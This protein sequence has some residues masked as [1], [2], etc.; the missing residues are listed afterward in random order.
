MFFGVTG[1]LFCCL[2]MMKCWI[3]HI[4]LLN[5]CDG[6]QWFPVF[7]FYIHSNAFFFS[8]HSNQARRCDSVICLDWN[9]YGNNL[10]IFIE[11]WTT[12]VFPIIT[13]NFGNLSLRVFCKYLQWQVLLNDRLRLDSQRYIFQK[14]K[15][16]VYICF[17]RMCLWCLCI[18]NTLNTWI[19]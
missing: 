10:N 9:I 12:F 5:F 11:Y 14:K 1:D 6:N 2:G 15:M 16:L 4:F 19:G 13:F 8:C 3:C 17:T 18:M 7:V